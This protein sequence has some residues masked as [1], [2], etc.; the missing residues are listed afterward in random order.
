MKPHQNTKNKLRISQIE[1]RVSALWF[2]ALRREA[3]KF[4]NNLHNIETTTNYELH[5]LN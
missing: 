2:P 1:L 3:A 5:E 4:S